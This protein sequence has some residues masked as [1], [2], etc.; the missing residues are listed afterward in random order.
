[1]NALIAQIIS[2]LSAELES[3]GDVRYAVRIIEGS[4]HL[5]H[6]Y[7]NYFKKQAW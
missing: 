4:V 3:S 6:F 5:N 1:M 2:T 7:A